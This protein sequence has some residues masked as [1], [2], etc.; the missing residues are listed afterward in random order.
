M[1]LRK[2]LPIALVA[3]A[4]CGSPNV[5]VA[6]PPP[7][8][9]VAAPIQRTVTEYLEFTGMTQPMETVEI[10]ARVRGFLKERH[11]VEGAEVK[12][13]QLLL[14]IDEEPFQ[15]QLEA[16]RTRFSEAEAALQQA[17]VSK[18]REVARA[19]VSL[20]QSQ[21]VLAGQEE[22]RVRSLFERQ[23]AAQGEMDQ[24]QATLKAREAEQESAVA[25]LAQAEAVYD[26]TI[27]TSRAQVESAAIAVR[28]AELDLSYCRMTAPIDGR[29]SRSNV[30]VG[31]LISGDGAVVLATIVRMDPIHVYATI[32]ESDLQRIPALRRSGIRS[33]A[34]ERTPTT[35]NL[36]VEL[37]LAS[38]TGYSRTGSINYTDPGLD[39][40]TGTLRV[41]GVFAN[42][43][44]DLMPGMFIRMR[45][46]ENELPNALLVPERALGTDQ[47]GQYVFVVDAENKVQYRP[48]KTGVSV[49]SLRVVEGQLAVTDKIIVEGLLRV[50]PG[51]TVVPQ[52]LPA[53]PGSDSR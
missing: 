5:Y 48:V 27:L 14:V 37:G 30:D 17:T 35:L 32:G 43:D 52:P 53:L 49:D 33:D 9:T 23:A 47:S 3:A 40:S 25:N 20:S 29:I 36:P 16:A 19:L 21:V 24:A 39:Q 12:K 41:R 2:L 13:G 46:A 28:N 51:A 8:V 11:F 31:N 42:P 10:R 4:G 1:N 44:R 38:E 18:S 26:T 34:A 50:R 15:I 7:E 6:P 22:K 45:L